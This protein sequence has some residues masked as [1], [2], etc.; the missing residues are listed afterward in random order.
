MSNSK[1]SSNERAV[2]DSAQGYSTEDVQQI[3]TIALGDDS[4]SAAELE[5]MANELS[6]DEMT[7]SY[8][9]DVWRSRKASAQQKQQRRQRF[10]RYELLPYLIVN[11]FLL[12]LDISIAGGVTWSIYPLLGW[13]LGLL[14]GLGGCNGERSSRRIKK[15]CEQGEM[16]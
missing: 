10:Y 3:L 11:G 9:V 1:F 13:G 8:A 7:L 16:A 6:I 5:E 12:V 14:L 2:A 15:L 4:S